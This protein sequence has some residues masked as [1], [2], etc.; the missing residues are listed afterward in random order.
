MSLSEAPSILSRRQT[1]G[2]EKARAT[3]QPNFS[4]K[5]SANNGMI[6]Q[7]SGSLV[8]PSQLQ[9]QHLKGFLPAHSL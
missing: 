2:D 5:Y 1:S 4:L 6:E 8:I 3:G 7:K 9:K